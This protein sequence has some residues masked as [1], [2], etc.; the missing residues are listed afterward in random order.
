MYT[1]RM[2]RELT[3]QI[4]KMF[5]RKGGIHITRQLLEDLASFIFSIEIT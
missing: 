1:K 5:Y 2:L 4:V 3:Y